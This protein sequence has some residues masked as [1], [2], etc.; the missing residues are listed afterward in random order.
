[1]RVDQMQDTGKELLIPAQEG[2]DG[3]WMQEGQGGRCG[4]ERGTD[5]AL[6]LPDGGVGQ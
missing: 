4:A 3:G 5:W 2:R 1:M 6:G